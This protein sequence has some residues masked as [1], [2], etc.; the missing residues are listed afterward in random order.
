MMLKYID[1]SCFQTL[2]CCIYHADKCLKANNCWHFNIYEYDKFHTQWSWGQFFFITSGQ[3]WDNKNLIQDAYFQSMEILSPLKYWLWAIKNWVP[4]TL[5]EMSTL[6]M[7]LPH[8]GLQIRRHNKNRHEKV[9]DW[10]GF[11][12]WALAYDLY[13]D[14]CFCWNLFLNEVKLNFIY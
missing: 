8:S 12:D 2:R 7:W 10:S 9:Q 5:G 13:D 14:S 4:R 1:F 3:V 11:P 6:K